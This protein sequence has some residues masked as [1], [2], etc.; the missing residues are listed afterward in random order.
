M[1][2][3]KYQIMKTIDA[4]FRLF[5][6]TLDEAIPAVASIVVFGFVFRQ[7]LIGVIATAVVLIVMR[8]LKRGKSGGFLLNAI[9]WQLPGVVFGAYLKRTP[10]SSN[11]HFIA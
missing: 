10:Q 9:Y 8:I 1:D 5:G 4:P 3:S 2:A 6:L 7:M 11:R